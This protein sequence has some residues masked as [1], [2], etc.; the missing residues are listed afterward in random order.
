MPKWKL[1]AVEPDTCDPWTEDYQYLDPILVIELE[2]I[3]GRDLTPAERTALEETRQHNFSGCRYYE[4]WNSLDRLGTPIVVCSSERICS[5]HAVGTEAAKGKLKWADG[6]WKDVGNYIT[7]QRDWFRWL[8]RLEWIARD[9]R[10]RQGNPQPIPEQI[11]SFTSEPTTPGSVTS[12][13]QAEQD[14]LTTMYE[15]NRDHNDRKG[16]A[17]DIMRTELNVGTEEERKT[18]DESISWRFEGTGDTRLLYVDSGGLLSVAER[19]RVASAADI[20]FG[21]DKVVVEG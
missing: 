9:P 20:Q 18:F 4:L 6:N 19:T 5:G 10:D 8:N 11:A 12:P 1:Q 13:S 3:L 7:Y 16:T 21:L 2:A 17:L 15:W 14:D